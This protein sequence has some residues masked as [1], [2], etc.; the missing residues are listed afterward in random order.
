MAEKGGLDE[1][2][3]KSVSIYNEGL[4]YFYDKQWDRAVEILSQSEK[5]EPFR[6]V[7][8]KGMSPSKKIMEYCS[9]Y[10]KEPP[11]ADWDGSIQ[12]TSK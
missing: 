6:D 11:P 5:T 2:V 9:Q 1:N 10:K 4:K 12:L 8:P 3:R 7:A